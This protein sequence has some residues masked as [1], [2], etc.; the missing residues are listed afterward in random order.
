MDDVDEDKDVNELRRVRRAVPEKINLQERLRLYEKA[1][2]ADALES[3]F[4]SEIDEDIVRADIP[5]RI[6]LIYGDR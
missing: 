2:G 4:V 3:M 5:E 1:F 6:Q